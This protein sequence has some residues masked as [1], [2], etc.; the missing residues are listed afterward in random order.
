MSGDR[1]G[2]PE[3]DFEAVM[4]VLGAG[5]AEV[6]PSP[7]LDDEDDGIFPT[8]MGGVPDDEPVM[9]AA[10][11]APGEEVDPWEADYPG[12]S[13]SEAEAAAEGEGGQAQGQ[14][15]GLVAEEE[16]PEDDWEIPE[17]AA[18]VEAAVA[19]RGEVPVEA[20]PVAAVQVDVSARGDREGPEIL[21]DVGKVGVMGGAYPRVLVDSGGDAATRA[22][23]IQVKQRLAFFAASVAPR[24]AIREAGQGMLA[25][26]AGK[27]QVAAV[28]QGSTKHTPPTATAARL[29][30]VD[31]AD[32]T[33]VAV[34]PSIVRGGLDVESVLGGAVPLAGGA[35]G[36]KPM[37]L[38]GIPGRGRVV[39]APTGGAG[40]VPPPSGVA[41]GSWFDRLA[42]PA[43][44]A[45][46]EDEAEVPEVEVGGGF[47][48]EADE[49]GPA[50]EAGLPHHRFDGGVIGRRPSAKGAEVAP[51]KASGGAPSPSPEKRGR[52]M[53]VPGPLGLETILVLAA[54]LLGCLVAGWWTE[55]RSAAPADGV[56]TMV[57]ER[58]EAVLA[59]LDSEIREIEHEVGEGDLRLLEATAKLGDM[60]SAGEM[61]RIE[62]MVRERAQAELLL[63]VLRAKKR[64]VAE[65]VVHGRR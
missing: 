28:P 32:P 24:Q 61:A 16:P 39:A 53:A 48:G 8:S 5:G 30:A 36:D 4:G 35:V 65:G 17:V 18:V 49:G 40:A 51:P 43:P 54:S 47:E 62:V 63:E 52:A 23:E 12:G 33:R 31:N 41:G 3:D 20:P 26:L 6:P 57:V 13:G 46:G 7:A 60:P 29:P 64:Q 19:E 10:E 27:D 34:G 55:G 11:E 56:V 21:G 14:G 44:G 37:V 42:A 1:V 2:L 50:A 22:R 58:R 45:Q 59:Y 9:E 15:Q 38:P 25:V